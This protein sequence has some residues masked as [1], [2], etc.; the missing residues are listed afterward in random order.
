MQFCQGFFDFI[1]FISSYFSL[2]PIGPLTCTY[3]IVG[4]RSPPISSRLLC[5]SIDIHC[6]RH[7]QSQLIPIF[8]IASEDGFLAHLL[9]AY[10][11]SFF[12]QNLFKIEVLLTP[13]NY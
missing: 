11:K 8:A 10:N 4:P 7:S 13:L 1:T 5:S 12:D 2:A 6:I 9:L 3:P